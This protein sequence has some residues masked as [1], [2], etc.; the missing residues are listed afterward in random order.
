MQMIFY[1]TNYKIF[2]HI[3]IQ[4]ITQ[5]FL[6]KCLKSLWAR[7]PLFSLTLDYKDIKTTKETQ[8]CLRKKQ[9]AKHL[10]LLTKKLKKR[11]I[12]NNF[13]TDHA[14][15]THIIEL[16]LSSRFSSPSA[17][18]SRITRHRVVAFEVLFLIF[19]GHERSN[20]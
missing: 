2:V 19:L 16:V 15:E 9:E 12:M 7:T 17:M 8:H 6:Q 18:V 1:N 10:D 5:I 13:S 4:Q 20:L 11:I 14:D 3:K